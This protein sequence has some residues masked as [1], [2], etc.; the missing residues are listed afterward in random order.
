MERGYLLDDFREQLA[1]ALKAGTDA[2]AI[3]RSIAIID[4]M[5]PA[6]RSDPNPIVLS[7]AARRR[8]AAMAGTTPYEVDQLL[9]RFEQVRTLMQSRKQ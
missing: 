2:E 8:I 6:E 3:G 7:K 4:A 1:V 5:T 9:T